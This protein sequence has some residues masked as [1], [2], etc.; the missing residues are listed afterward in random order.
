MPT[1]AIFEGIVIMMYLTTKEHLPPHIHAIYGERN[2]TFLIENGEMYK[3]NIPNKQ[4][5]LITRFVLCYK[6]E[7]QEM[8]DN[9]EYKK[10]EFK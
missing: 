10:L 1:I 9:M 2:G 7:L 5:D 8:W 6:K 3:G 4:K